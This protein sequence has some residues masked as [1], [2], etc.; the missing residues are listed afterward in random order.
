MALSTDIISYWK[1]NEASSANAVD[2]HGSNT[3]TDVNG[4][5]AGIGAKIGTSRFLIAAN[6]EYFTVASNSS[7]QTGD[8]GF[9]FAGWVRLS[10]SATGVNEIVL[11]K[12]AG[13]SHEYILYYDPLSFRFIWGVTSSGLDATITQLYLGSGAVTR[14]LWHHVVVWHDPAANQIGGTVNNG[15]PN[16]GSHSGGVYVGSSVFRFG[17]T[18]DTNAFLNGEVDEWGFWKKVLTS[19]E[20]SLLYNSGLAKT[21]PFVY[22][23]GAAALTA[24]ATVAPLGKLTANGI[25]APSGTVTVD[26]V[27]KRIQYGTAA[28]ASSATVDAVGFHAYGSRSVM[29]AT[30]SLAAT[31]TLHAV[32]AK[33]FTASIDASAVGTRHELSSAE[34]TATLTCEGAGT[35]TARASA[36]LGALANGTASVGVERLGAAVLVGSC[37]VQA[38]AGSTQPASAEL[39]CETTLTSSGVRGAYGT[40]AIFASGSLDAL[41]ICDYSA[42]ASGGAVAGSSAFAGVKRFGASALNGTA[43]VAASGR[44]K[45]RPRISLL[46]S[47]SV[48]ATGTADHFARA[49]LE[50]SGSLQA[51]SG[52]D[53][54]ASASLSGNASLQASPVATARAA[55]ALTAS[56]SV[57]ALGK[58]TQLG[59]SALTGSGTVAGLGVKEVRGASAIVGTATLAASAV[60]DVAASSALQATASVAG[61]GNLSAVAASALT[62]SVT[63]SARY[64]QHLS[65]AIGRKLSDSPVWDSIE[66]R[67]YP[68]RSPQDSA[69]PLI[70]YEI[71]GTEH[72][73]ELTSTA[74]LARADVLFVVVADTHEEKLSVANELHEALAD[75]EGDWSSVDVVCCN[76]TR[77]GDD[78]TQ[79]AW[80]RQLSFDVWYRESNPFNSVAI[81]ES[82]ESVEESIGRYL[83]D[84]ATVEPAHLH[85]QSD[86]PAILYERIASEIL[87]GVSGECGIQFLSFRMIV[88]TTRY[89]RTAS[90]AE[91]LRNRLDGL[92][93]TMQGTRTYSVALENETELY[94]REG[95]GTESAV[96][97]VEHEYMIA[98]EQN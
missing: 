28:L 91:Q 80:Q 85:R 4:I 62:A 25:A 6:S 97:I 30:V 67:L 47:A 18:G 11:S 76:M 44:M 29:P 42:S 71:E 22:H 20:R 92:H 61:L 3:L 55:S 83:A 13:S 96:W 68:H 26:A 15:S 90:L 31:G 50:A 58:R 87:S 66:G 84:L 35:L 65:E 10:T 86:R 49:V 59:A 72:S 57:A 88:S 52:K 93:G 39:N 41:A 5:A 60:K 7:L 27:G 56:A 37:T 19:D 12:W 46:T 36:A 63:V 45:Y 73:P 79:D 1:F 38:S 89:E 17:A 69:L 53:N 8:I 82:V 23:D 81:L 2:S 21:Y 16:T 64:W 95:S 78:D 14:N 24:S 75:Q 40:V 48:A 34:L 74:G 70:I 98:V 43:S 32:G 51:H 54:P 77:G 33:A 94:E 9:S